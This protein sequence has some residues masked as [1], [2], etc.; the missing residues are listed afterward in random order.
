MVIWGCEDMP[1]SVDKTMVILK[2]V[3]D[4]K[5]EPVS[6]DKIS[7]ATGINKSTASHIISRLCSGGYLVRVSHSLGYAPGPELHI[8]TRYGRYGEKIITVARPILE[9]LHKKTG[10]VA[11][12]AVI[13]GDKKYIIDRYPENQ[14]YRDKEAHI[15]SDDLYRTVTGRVLLANITTDKALEIYRT[16]GAPQVGEWKEAMTLDGFLSELAAIRRTVCYYCKTGDSSS[17][18]HS[19][20]TPIFKG[21]TCEAALGLAIKVENADEN[22]NFD[23]AKHSSLMIKCRKEIERRLK[24]S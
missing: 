10:A 24:F 17:S 14:I 2:A 16:L 1:N 11:I 13:A 4:G 6:L 23:T 5:G 12:F 19:F 9:Y 20:A 3:S 18:W 21:K 7:N 22:V 8:L 15:L